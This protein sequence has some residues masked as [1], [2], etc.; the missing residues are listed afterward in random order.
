MEDD[1]ARSIKI[2]LDTQVT[3][4]DMEVED[5][6]EVVGIGGAYVVSSIIQ[7]NQT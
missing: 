5:D 6:G 2:K 7:S 4:W 3:K 1:D